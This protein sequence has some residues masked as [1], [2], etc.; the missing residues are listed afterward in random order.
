M[1]DEAEVLLFLIFHVQNWLVVAI[2]GI[3]YEVVES[4]FD[5][6][7]YETEGANSIV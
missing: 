1:E 5:F 7:C 2:T 6:K 3:C 4:I